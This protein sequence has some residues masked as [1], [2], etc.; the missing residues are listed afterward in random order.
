MSETGTSVA[1]AKLYPLI[2]SR[3]R[4]GPNEV[5]GKCSQMA[6]TQSANVLLTKDPL[7]VG[8]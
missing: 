4:N 1:E 8:K 7:K 3:H 5:S 2:I 6:F